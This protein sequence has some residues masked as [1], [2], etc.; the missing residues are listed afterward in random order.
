MIKYLSM[1]SALALTLVGMYYYGFVQSYRSTDDAF[2]E[3]KIT[4]VAPKISGRV[5]QVL[6]DDNQEVRKGDLL[7]TIGAG[8]Y[9]AALRQKRAALDSARAQAVAVQAS[10][11]QQEAHINTLEATEEADWATAA[12]D[13]ANAVNAAALFKRTQELFSRKVVAPQDLDMAKANAEATQA[14]LDAALKKVATDEAQMKEARYQ[15]QTYLALLQSVQALIAEADANLESAKLNRSYADIQAPENGRITNKTVQPGNYIQIGQVL[16]SLVPSDVYVIA[17]FKENQ[18]GK[19][20]PGQPVT[21]HIDSLPGQKFAGH[22]HSIQAGSGARF[23]LLPPENATGNYVKVV[24]RVPVKI[25][26]DQVPKIGLPIGPGE[27]V[28]P[29]VKVQDFH[30]SVAQLIGIGGAVAVMLWLINRRAE[31][32]PKKKELAPGGWW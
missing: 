11:Q 1:G 30:Y 19:M 14:T 28:I 13:R 18:I 26:F 27:S 10:I 21:I 6:V 3:G 25:L 23:S 4:D 8:D 2:I 12:A 22:I 9:D 24:Q 7:V 31:R 5:E 32:P 17:N 16:L 15:V 29:V 20:R